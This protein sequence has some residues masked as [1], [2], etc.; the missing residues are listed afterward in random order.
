[1]NLS[2]LNKLLE[3]YYE[4]FLSPADE[5]SLLELLSTEDL[6]AEYFDDKMFVTTL[7][8]RG[9]DIPEPPAGLNDRI[10]AAIDESEKNKKLIHNKRRFF[11]VLSAAASIL[12]IISFWF[13][14]AD[15][16]RLKDTYQDPQLAYNETVKI[17]YS[18][19]ANLNKGMRQMSDISMIA[20][21]ESKMQM[22][23][24]S[25]SAITDELEPLKYLDNSMRLLNIGQNNNPENGK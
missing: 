7:H 13:I 4:G 17:L 15:N 25:R 18:L 10:M 20:H 19:S 12:I 11:A 9:D 14:L 24:E 1:M 2:R 16:D 5:K 6:P 21:A 3:E 22:I 8:G 23:S